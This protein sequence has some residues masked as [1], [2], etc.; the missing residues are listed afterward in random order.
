M[1]V[2]TRQDN[3]T[4]PLILDGYSFAKNGTIAQDAVRTIPLAFGTVMAYN[5]ADM[6]WVP[7]T[8]L[9]NLEGESVPQGIFLGN[10]I[11]A[12]A[13]VAGDTED[14]PILVGGSAVLNED[15]LVWDQD[16]QTA[17]SVISAAAAVPY[18]VISAAQCL[19]MFG[20]YIQV[21]EAIDAF[22]N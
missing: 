5:T 10:A 11:T 15:E 6:E 12:A 16:L 22:E 17:D 2:Q 18:F 1:A 13:M 9:T 7:F 8:A 4:T 14:Q 19:G 21:S 3:S 20:L